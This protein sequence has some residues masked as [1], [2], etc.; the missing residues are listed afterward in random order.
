VLQIT[1]DDADALWQQARDAGA[2]VVH[3]L[4]D[5]F[6]GERHGQLTDPFGHRWNIAQHVRDVPPDEVAAAAAAALGGKDDMPDYEGPV[7]TALQTDNAA[8]FTRVHRVTNTQDATL[9]AAAFGQVFAPDV[10]IHIPLPV[11]STGVQALKDLFASFTAR[12]SS[13]ALPTVG[14]LRSGVWSMSWRNYGSSACSQTDERY[15]A[16]LAVGRRP[17]LDDSPLSLCDL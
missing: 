12:S 6:W 3:E 13:S 5:Q 16:A 15:A 11:P 14:S 1:A 2:T 4:A 7:S 9:I 10:L 17:G 8:A